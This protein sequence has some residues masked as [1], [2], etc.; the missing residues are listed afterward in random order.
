MNTKRK[1]PGYVSRF[2]LVLRDQTASVQKRA[3]K[4][5][6]RNPQNKSPTT[7]VS[8][9]SPSGILQK[10]SADETIPRIFNDFTE[11]EAICAFFLDFVLLPRNKDSVQGHLEH[12]LPLYANTAPD[13][14]LSLAT[15]AVALVLSGS[16]PRRR[17]DQDRARQNFG[18]AIQKTRDAIRS[19]TESKKDETLMAVL[20]LGLYEVS[21][22]STLL[23]S[24]E[25]LCNQE[26][27]IMTPRLALVA[28]G[29]HFPCILYPTA[30]LSL[31]YRFL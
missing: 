16:S 27:E 14:P 25:A 31:W 19:P 15:S 26:A 6:A 13:S 18:K 12:L 21:E 3:Q 11:Q 2:D 17:T 10:P 23:V 28:S 5:K 24:P 4:T 22:I 9:G 20:V 7:S 8:S 30:I 1:C 29:L